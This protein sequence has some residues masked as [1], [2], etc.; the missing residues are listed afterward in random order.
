MK[1]LLTVFTLVMLLTSCQREEV[2]DM[3]TTDFTYKVEDNDYSIPVKIDFT[4]KSFGAHSYKW[5]FEGGSPETSDSKDPGI[6]IFNNAGSIKIKL[7]VWNGSEHK[8]KDITIVLDSSLQANFN[9]TP[10]INNFGPTEFT[11]ANQSTGTSQYQWTF[12]GGIP[13]SSTEK[14]PFVSFSQPGNYLVTLY[15][16]NR[17]G[18]QD[19][20]SKTVTV[21]PSMSEADFDIIPSFEDDD[22]EAP[23]TATLNNLTTHATLHQWSVSGGSLNNPHDSTPTVQFTYP[24]TYAI[25]YLAGNGKQT[26]TVSKTITVK[27][28]SGLRTF[29]DIKLGINSAHNTIGSFFSTQLRRVLKQGEVDATSGSKIDLVFFGLSESF[30]FNLFVSPDATTAWTFAAIPGAQ[31]TRYVNVQ[32]SCG[33]GPTLTAADFDAITNGSMLQTLN[34]PEETNNNASFSN[35]VTPRVVLFRNAAG[36]KGA[37]KIKQFV[38]DGLQSYIECDIKIQKD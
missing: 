28:N 25:T 16:T 22:Y 38:P 17:R 9:I 36:K 29:T 35:A 33:C 10:V 32:E 26:D 8:E 6:V 24:G 27:P 3:I 1:Q 12:Y 13:S 18:E 11:I 5:S 20:L 30:A 7:E 2:E 21:L 15:V 4:N 19:S 23:L 14:N 37:I 31:K 34:I